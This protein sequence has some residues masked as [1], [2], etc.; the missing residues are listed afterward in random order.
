MIVVLG[1]AV[2]AGCAP[3]VSRQAVLNALVGQ[4]ETEALRVLGVP[5]RSFQAN[6]HMFLAYDDRRLDYVPVGPAFSP[7]G[8]FG[9]FGWGYYVPPTVPV[10]RV[11]ETT[12]EVI[13]GRVASWALRGSAC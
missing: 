8:P 6:G 11:C 9:G 5:N 12:L 4:P 2:L 7:W 13:D 10:E 3:G 1:V